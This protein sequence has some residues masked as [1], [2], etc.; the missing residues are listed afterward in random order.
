MVRPLPDLKLGQPEAP[1]PPHG[2]TPPRHR[3]ISPRAI[4]LA[5]LFIPPAVYWGSV[6][7]VDVIMSLMIPPVACTFLVA[8]LNLLVARLR[9][10][11]Q[12]SAGELVLFYGMVS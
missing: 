12:L 6:Q 8:V 1:P 9:P 3:A 11:R 5:L 2:R 4:L 10:G 7:G